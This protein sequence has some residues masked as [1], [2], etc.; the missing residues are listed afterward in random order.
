MK[1]EKIEKSVLRPTLI[2]LLIGTYFL[3]MRNPS[4]GDGYQ[5]AAWVGV[6]II[7]I[8][9]AWKADDL[10]SEA[11]SFNQVLL[12]TVLYQRR[13]ISRATAKYPEFMLPTIGEAM[14]E[15]RVKREERDK[16]E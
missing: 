16:S 5:A 6:T 13:V 10:S 8:L 7:W 14:R 3:Y 15:S 1:F 4:Y 2:V 9:L 11:V 12:D